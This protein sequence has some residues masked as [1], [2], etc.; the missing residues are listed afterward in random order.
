MKEILK[1]AIL[2]LNKTRLVE[3]L[4]HSLIAGGKKLP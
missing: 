3:N 1:E 2:E 4:K